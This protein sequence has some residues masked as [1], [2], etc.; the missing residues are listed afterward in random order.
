MGT[1][2]PK[3][4]K[5]GVTFLGN[6]GKRGSSNQKLAVK[7]NLRGNIRGGLPLLIPSKIRGNI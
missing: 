6:T 2:M 4:C 5:N 3:E 1:D 7:S